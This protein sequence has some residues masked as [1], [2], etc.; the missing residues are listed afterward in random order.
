MFKRLKVIIT[1]LF[2]M[3]FSVFLYGS[4][5]QNNVKPD[6]LKALTYRHIGPVGNRVVAI[7][8]KPGNS[9]VIYAGGATG[10]V[11][12]SENGGITWKPLFDEQDVQT[13]GSLAMAPADSNIIWCG[14][15]EAKI[16]Q[17]VSIGNGIYKSIDGGKTWQCMGLEKSGRISRILIH[18]TNSDIV[19]A[20]SLGHCWGPQKERGVFRTKDGGKAWEQVLLVDKDTGVSDMDMDPKNPNNIIVGMWPLLLQVHKRTSGGPGGGIYR[21]Q[22]GGDTWERLLKGLPKPPTGRIAVRYAPS[23]PSRVYALIETAQ[24]EFIGVLW[25]SKDGGDTWNLVS[26]DHE[27]QTR[28]H[29]YTR[30]DIAVDDENEVYFLATAIS[31]SYDGGKTSEVLFGGDNHDSWFDPLNPNRMLVANDRGVNISVDRG[32][33]WTN[34]KIPVAQM[35]HVSTDNRIPYNVYGNQQ[36]AG[37][38]WGPSNS[39][40]G[41]RGGAGRIPASSWKTAAGGEAG[42][43]YCDPV[44]NNIIWSTNYN[45]VSRFDLRTG[46]ARNVFPSMESVF[47]YPPSVIK[48]RWNWSPP[49][50]ISPHDHNK[51]Y[52]GSQHL[53]T[54]SNGGQSWQKISP[55]LTLNDK[56]KQTGSGGLIEDNLGVDCANTL[57]AIAESPL[58]KDMIWVGTNDGLIHLTLDG[59]KTWTRVSDNFPKDV[60]ELGIVDRIKPSIYNEETA[61]VA[62]Q[63][64]RLNDRNPYIL[65]TEDSGK[66]WRLISKGIPKSVHS[67]IR[68]IEE[69]PERQ[70]LLFAGTE[71]SVYVSFNDGANWMLLQNNLPYA[72]AT[73]LEVQPHFG[74]L[75][76]GTYGRGFWIMDDISPLRQLTEAVLQSDVYL[77]NPRAAYRFHM[78]LP[79]I[80]VPTPSDGTNPQYGA[81][82]NYYLKDIPDGNVKIEILEGDKLIRT[83]S[84]TK[85]RGINRVYWDLRQ[86]RTKRI[87]LRTLPVG[88]PVESH[89]IPPRLHYNAEGWRSGGGGGLGPLVV[90]G[91]FIIRMTVADR[92]FTTEVEVR[93]DPNAEGTVED[94]RAQNEF[95]FKAQGLFDKAAEIVN[96]LEWIRKQID[97]LERMASSDKSLLADMKDFDQKIIEYEGKFVQVWNTGARNNGLR[98]AAGIVAQIN[99]LVGNAALYDFKPADTVHVRYDELSQELSQ[100]QKEHDHLVNSELSKFNEMLKKRYLSVIVIPENR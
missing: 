91:N 46:H 9:N 67:Y 79:H 63:K 31:R 41:G 93:K 17:G 26:Y 35:Y 22:D 20:G 54:S 73:W 55:D 77:F 47:G 44:D 39:L 59:G 23:N 24:F 87:K 68:S 90:P 14:T 8:G 71:N 66:S 81:A 69:D 18:P 19:F 62:Y 99:N 72:P 15:G 10:G 82:I 60:P 96:D 98:G 88:N 36:D 86:G 4:F 83:L 38:K 56:S 80:S 2:T 61:Y 7:I 42:F 51:V 85:E 45:S 1:T 28:A 52:F 43:T 89:F 94:I 29:Y 97:D 95:Y 13:I 57:F 65:K 5:A 70:G 21:S 100:L 11:W 40:Y 78:V 48:E 58:R 50:A 27:L 64:H 30:L 92:S 37:S 49:F 12:K 75:V 25:D 3:F 76:V 53:M 16:R 32:K 33:T 84:G 6:L 34:P 74:D